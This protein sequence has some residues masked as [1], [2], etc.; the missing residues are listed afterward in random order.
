MHLNRLRIELDLECESL[1]MFEAKVM[2]CKIGSEFMQRVRTCP[3]RWQMEMKT[4]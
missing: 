1:A 3:E 2:W 4:E